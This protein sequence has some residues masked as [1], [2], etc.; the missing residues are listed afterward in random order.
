MEHLELDRWRLWC[1]CC[2]L[3]HRFE[4]SRPRLEWKTWGA[5]TNYTIP[6]LIEL[7]FC[8]PYTVQ[9]LASEEFGLCVLSLL[10]S[11]LGFEVEGLK[12]FGFR[13]PAL[14]SQP[15]L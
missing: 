1:S 15:L 9:G 4:G 13:L 8:C 14:N 6:R 2:T 7:N 10:F 3:P 5:L 11:R 12:G